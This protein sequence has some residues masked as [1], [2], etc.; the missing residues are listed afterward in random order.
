M[1]VSNLLSMRSTSLTIIIPA[2]ASGA[3]VVDDV[4]AF[5]MKT[6]ISAT[7]PVW[8]G[9]GALPITI[10][11]DV[12]AGTNYQVRVKA[13][14]VASLDSCKIRRKSGPGSGIKLDQLQVAS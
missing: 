10:V 12:S 1:P 7:G 3:V 8:N 11:T 4:S 6:T 9:L 5:P 13:T 2:N 14:P